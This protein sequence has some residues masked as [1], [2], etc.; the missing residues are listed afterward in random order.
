MNVEVTKEAPRTKPKPELQSAPKPEPQPEPQLKPIQHSHT[1][2][3]TIGEVIFSSETFYYHDRIPIDGKILI[4]EKWFVFLPDNEVNK[5]NLLCIPMCNIAWAGTNGDDYYNYFIAV[6]TLQEDKY[7][8]GFRA[9]LGSDISLLACK[10]IN[11]YRGGNGSR[12]KSLSSNGSLLIDSGLYAGFDIGAK[13]VR[14]MLSIYNNCIVFTD[15]RSNEHTHKIDMN[16]VIIAIKEPGLIN[17]L[18]RRFKVLTRQN[19]EYI[20]S[21]VTKLKDIIDIINKYKG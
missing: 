12:R 4:S 10:E 3:E 18:D 20:Y 17:K 7:R 9:K 5:L 13:T 15:D 6:F 1:I 14:G 21:M 19:K 11:E 2:P 8:F 16:D